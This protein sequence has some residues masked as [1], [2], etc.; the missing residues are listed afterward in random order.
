[1]Q[2]T[3]DPTDNQLIDA[4]PLRTRRRPGSSTD[5]ELPGGWLLRHRVPTIKRCV[6]EVFDAR[7]DLVGLVASSARA[8]A[9]IDEAW[10]GYTDDTHSERRWWSLAMGH[11]DGDPDALVTFL[12][13]R[14]DGRTGRTTVMPI[15]IDG[16]WIAMV[17]AR[18]DV[19]TLHHGTR[20]FVHRIAPTLRGCV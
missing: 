1:M 19:V 16:L 6:L 12:G 13:R 11:V 18:R 9:S 20:D 10:R 8:S 3:T 7:H 5:V 4:T 14:P 17:P 2:S 15:V